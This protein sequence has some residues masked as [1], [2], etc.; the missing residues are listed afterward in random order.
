MKK[1]ETQTDSGGRKTENEE[2]KNRREVKQKRGEDGK[3][4]RERWREG[5]RKG[6]WREC[7]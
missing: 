2:S 5:W 7:V 4:G 1:G 3:G 6:V